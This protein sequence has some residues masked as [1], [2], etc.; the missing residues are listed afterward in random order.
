MKNGADESVHPLTSLTQISDTTGPPHPVRSAYCSR[1]ICHTHMS[2]R[3]GGR[4][5][6]G[7]DLNLSHKAFSPTVSPTVWLLASQEGISFPG[8][9]I[10]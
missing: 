10:Y 8:D 6:G 2:G 1:P 5:G 3:E 4:D 7:G 9:H